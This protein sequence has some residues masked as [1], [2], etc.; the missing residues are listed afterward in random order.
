MEFDLWYTERHDDKFGITIKV[1]ETLYHDKSE[2]QTIDVINTEGFGRMLLLDGLVMTTEQDEFVYH[3]MISHIPMLNHP[4]PEQVLVIGGGDG[5]TIREV[6]KHSSVKRAVLCEI[7]GK[8]IEAS[9]KFLPTIAGKLDDPKVETQVR[10]GVTYIAEQKGIFDVILI[11][12]TDPL[13]PGEGLFTED[14]YTNVKAALK[15][16]GIV[17]AQSESPIADKREIS[18]MYA[19]LRKVFPIV[20]PYVGPIPTYPGGYWS[21]AYCSVDVNPFDRINDTLAAQIEK[22]TKY[23][24]RDI[25]RAAFALPNFVK[26]L[27]QEKD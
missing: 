6:L 13:G 17:V 14:F 5:G 12:S 10:D 11:D 25:H 18:L 19:L 26:Q 8:V 16:G 23:Y 20:K 27:T 1:K 21:W 22:T 4:N 7:D 2:F 9:K 24:N 15:P 3:E